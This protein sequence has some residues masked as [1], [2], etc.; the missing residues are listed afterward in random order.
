[1]YAMK[2]LHQPYPWAKQMPAFETIKYLINDVIQN[3]V[4][5]DDPTTK[6]E[7]WLQATQRPKEWKTK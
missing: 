4:E 2:E 5:Y 3:H 1:M 7:R 6:R